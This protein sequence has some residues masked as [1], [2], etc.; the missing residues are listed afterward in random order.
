MY[1]MG[2]SERSE[3]SNIPSVDK[4]SNK[5]SKSKYDPSVQRQPNSL[6]STK[7]LVSNNQFELERVKTSNVSTYS[8]LG[9]Q[10]NGH[11]GTVS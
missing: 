8:T 10:E 3:R 9:K 6:H 2:R 4:E 11:A 7:S 1:R 5:Y